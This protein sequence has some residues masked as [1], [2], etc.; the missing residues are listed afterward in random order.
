MSALVYGISYSDLLLPFVFTFL[1]FLI[2]V[3]WWVP[4]LNQVFACLFILDSSSWTSSWGWVGSAWKCLQELLMFLSSFLDSCT[5]VWSQSK[6]IAS[7]L[8]KCLP[9]LKHC[10]CLVHALEAPSVLL[11]S[12]LTESGNCIVVVWGLLCFVVVFFLSV[13]TSLQTW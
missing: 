7:R 12:L 11:P 8:T 3:G 10:P 4:V 1:L 5:R 6:G 13:Y 9:G 2:K